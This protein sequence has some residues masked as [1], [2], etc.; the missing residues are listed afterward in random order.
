V[1]APPPAFEW[2]YLKNGRVTHALSTFTG[3]RFSAECGIA[4]WAGWYGTG[5]Q[6]EYDRVAELP[7][8]QNCV[9]V[10]GPKVVGRHVPRGRM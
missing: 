9:K 7:Q 6:D 1:T 10:I 4:G 5:S 2:L 3:S 8:C